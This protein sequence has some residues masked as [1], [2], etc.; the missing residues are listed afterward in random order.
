MLGVRISTHLWWRVQG[1]TIQPITPSQWLWLHCPW[2]GPTCHDHLICTGRQAAGQ[3]VLILPFSMSHLPLR[4]Y[5]CQSAGTWAAGV[6]EEAGTSHRLQRADPLSNWGPPS[7]V[8][9]S[10]S[11]KHLAPACQHPSVD[12]LPQPLASLRRPGMCLQI[13]PLALLLWAPTFLGFLLVCSPYLLV[14]QFCLDL[15][16]CSWQPLRL[17]GVLAAPSHI[18]RWL[19]SSWMAQ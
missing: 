12:P 17:S 14:I 2:P 16:N 5:P 7:V 8:P 13:L 1:D 3:R 4:A 6:W 18:R 19:L 15:A 10:H 11:Q 9:L